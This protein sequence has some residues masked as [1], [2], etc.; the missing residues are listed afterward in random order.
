MERDLQMTRSFVRPLL[1]S[2]LIATGGAA[3]TAQPAAH[4]EH[5]ARMDRAQMQ[6]RHSERQAEL[7]E[8]L[9]LSAAQQAAWAAYAAAMQPP[10][11]A[12]HGGG[13][14]DRHQRRA[15]MQALTTPERI[16]RMAAMQQQRHAEMTRRGNA[17]K[18]FYAALDPDQQ[19]IFDEHWREHPRSGRH[20]PRGKD[21]PHN[22]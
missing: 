18:A 4:A 1:A 11:D 17:T 21:K 5:H 8:R 10:A 6:Q 12:G 15:E 13:A 2:V 14:Q 16:D 22:G 9:N 20:G 19:K 7:R 3:A